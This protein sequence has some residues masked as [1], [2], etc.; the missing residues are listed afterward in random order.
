MKNTITSA[1]IAAA[2]S[3]TL[4]MPTSALAE[5]HLQS[6]FSHTIDY[7]TEHGVSVVRSSD[8]GSLVVIETDF[9]TR[10]RSELRL[11][12]GRDGMFMPEADLGP[13][14]RVT[15]LQVFKAPPGLDIQQYTEVHIWNPQ[16]NVIVGFAPLN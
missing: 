6:Q 9:N 7:I 1:L 8:G 4:L 13:L 12:L 2:F 5:D 10:N 15:G 11:L 16:H 3:L 14:A